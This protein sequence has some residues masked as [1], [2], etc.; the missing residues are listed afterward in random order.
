[1]VRLI[2]TR[3]ADQADQLIAGL[4][5]MGH[6]VLHMPLMD[7]RPIA[8][9]DSRQAL[10]ARRCFLDLDYY[11]MVITI[12]ANAS[13]LGLEW[14]DNYWP[15][16][17]VGIQWFGVG[18]ASIAPLREAALDA[19]CPAHQF[20]SEGLLALPELHAVQHQK[21]LIWR[22]LG[23]RETLAEVLR[24]RGAQVDYAELY[25]RQALT[26][27]TG[28]WSEALEGRPWLL[29]SSGQALD[30]VM[31]QVPDLPARV[32]GLLLP[33]ERVATQARDMG[34]A[35][36]LVPASAGD[37]DTLDCIKQHWR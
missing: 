3:P 7:I 31:R 35:L 9:D 11:H 36:V 23:G 15:Q 2:V 22:G 4:Q 32:S 5:A 12:S 33:S 17:P 18:P 8:D 34:F 26:Y 29:L 28:Q 20:D 10:V 1:M 25:E 24:Q 30:I 19:Q 21:V 13:R 14:L 37:Q 16:A 6:D 27:S